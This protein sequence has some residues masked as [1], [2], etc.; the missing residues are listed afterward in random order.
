M[1]PPAR[2]ATATLECK[3]V[4]SLPDLRISNRRRRWPWFMLIGARRAL[5][6]GLTHTT[7]QRR[8]HVARLGSIINGKCPT[9]SPSACKLLSYSPRTIVELSAALQSRQDGKMAMHHPQGGV[10]KAGVGPSRLPFVS[11]SV[12]THH[13]GRQPPPNLAVK[14]I[15]VSLLWPVSARDTQRRRAC[16]INHPATGE[17][18]SFGATLSN[19]TSSSSI[20]RRNAAPPRS[21]IEGT[22]K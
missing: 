13:F 8:R 2:C 19:E 11:S 21:S 1:G 22:S 3:S 9:D 7:W 20:P 10:G 5:Q 16:K 6:A 14:E 12:S 15:G 4:L 18:G 17:F